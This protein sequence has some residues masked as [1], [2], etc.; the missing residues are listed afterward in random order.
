MFVDYKHI[1][2][3]FWSTNIS[4]FPVVSEA[5]FELQR[6]GIINDKQCISITHLINPVAHMNKEMGHCDRIR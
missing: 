6:T 3:S 5:C 2:I 1:F 4:L